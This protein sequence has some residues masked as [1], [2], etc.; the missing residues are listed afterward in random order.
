MGRSALQ[1]ADELQDLSNSTGIAT[2]RLLE[3]KK[4]LTTSGGEAE[5]MPQAINTFIRSIDEAAQGSIKAQNTF[6]ELG[7]SLRD[8]QT[9]GEQELMIKTLEGIAKI[10]DAGR[11]AT[12]MMDKFGKSFKT[13]DPGEL[14]QKLRATAG[15]GDAYAKTIKDA[16]ALNDQLAT[17][18]G[19]LK[20][21]FLQT[22]APV[23]RMMADFKL[24]VAVAN[25]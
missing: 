2:G 23:I 10:D 21:A 5:M 25:W 6:F 16:A 8:L 7:I 18:T 1:M 22:F 4:A 14:A 17:A 12:L 9:L 24:P 3:F 13:V 20:L 15:E 11:R 19:N